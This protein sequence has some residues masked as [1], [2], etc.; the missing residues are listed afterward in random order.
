VIYGLFVVG[1]ISS[2]LLATFWDVT[3]LVAGASHSTALFGLVF[4]LSLVDC[5]RSRFREAL[6]VTKKYLN[7]FF[8][9]YFKT[10]TLCPGGICSIDP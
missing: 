10:T 8:L 9:S 7:T 1:L 5:T 6:F 4:F 3:S 2:L